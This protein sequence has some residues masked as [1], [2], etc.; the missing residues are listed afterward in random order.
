MADGA[1]HVI[2]VHAEDFG[3]RAHVEADPLIGASE[4]VRALGMDTLIGYIGGGHWSWLLHDR[5]PAEGR[6]EFVRS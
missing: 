1:G 4:S 6:R 3:K 2:D 5:T